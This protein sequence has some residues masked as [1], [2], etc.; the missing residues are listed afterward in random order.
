MRTKIIQAIREQAALT[1]TPG[2][3]QTAALTVAQT[4]QL[5]GQFGATLKTIEVLALE[6]GVIPLRY[7]RNLNT[8]TAA[9]QITLLQSRVAV[10]GLG[11]LGGAMVEIL[12]RGG[13]GA[14]DLVDGD[15]FEDH[16]LNRQFLSHQESLGTSKAK[17]A[18]E[19]IHAVNPAVE[20]T[21]H[22]FPLTP[23]NASRLIVTCRV[24]VDCLDSIG[25][26]FT[27]EAAAKAS[28]LPMVSAAVAGLTGHVTTIFPEDP[29]LALIYGSPGDRQPNKGAETTLGCLPQA[30]MAVAAIESAQVIA[31]LLGRTEGVLR[32]R[33]LYIDLNENRFDT[34]RLA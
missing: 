26:R 20:V 15:R 31:V 34:L 1:G 13:V 32:N 5:S 14:L 10:I 25:T 9:D 19:R 2:G 28:G 30:V 18:R 17:A 29:G 11:G 7:Q 33:M 22:D 21:I 16:N 24:V 12:A 4:E 23:E 3:E 6:T 27:L 8:F